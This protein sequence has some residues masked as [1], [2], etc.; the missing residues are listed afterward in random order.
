M[1]RSLNSPRCRVSLWAIYVQFKKSYL[2]YKNFLGIPLQFINGIE[3][4]SRQE[5]TRND[6]SHLWGGSCD[7]IKMAESG[8]LAFLLMGPLVTWAR[9]LISEPVNLYQMRWAV[10]LLLLLF[11]GLISLF[12]I[13]HAGFF[14]FSIPLSF[15]RGTSD[16]SLWS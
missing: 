7:E 2:T 11:W 8:G 13:T 14:F 3:A 4:H 5:R 1:F 15:W 10:R 16:I 6:S 12:V 9:H